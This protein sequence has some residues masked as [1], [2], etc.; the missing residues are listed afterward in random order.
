MILKLNFQNPNSR[1]MLSLV[2]GLVVLIGLLMAQQGAAGQA[3][4]SPEPSFTPPVQ[5]TPESGFIRD[6]AD[7][8]PSPA[9][10]E[11]AGPSV[12]DWAGFLL[13][14][15]LVLLVLYGT[16]RGLRM[17]M[18]R[19]RWLPASSNQVSIVE[20]THLAPRRALYLV[21]VGGQTLLL[22]GTDH[23]ITLLAELDEVSRSNPETHPQGFAM[24]LA[25]AGQVVGTE[26]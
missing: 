1:W 19:Q 20:T 3:N 11:L 12:A 7:L 23:A 4:R 15:G 26:G 21:R 6:Y 14:F 8:A 5:I 9:Y 24:K 18:T 2:I 16:L 13:K 25:A 17:L 10:E 22:G